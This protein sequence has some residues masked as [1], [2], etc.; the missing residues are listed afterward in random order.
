[1]ATLK[2]ILHVDDEPDIRE[3]VRMSLEMVGGF[4]LVQYA[5]GFEALD[6]AVADAADLIILD[7][8]MPRLD[9]EET[10]RRLR[11]ISALNDTPIVFMTARVSAADFEKL[12]DLGAD[13]VLVKPFDPM[14]L[15]EQ[16][17]EIWQRR[18]G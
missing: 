8:M 7:V 5:S 9:G 11:E 12:K 13:D 15:P 17:R 18:Q 1:M 14:A 4:E 2:R 6:N 3:I 16:V 10:F